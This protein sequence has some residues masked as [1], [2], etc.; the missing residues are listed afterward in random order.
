MG[1]SSVFVIRADYLE[2]FDD[3]TWV[4]TGSQ[5]SD[6]PDNEDADWVTVVLPEEM[7]FTHSDE[8]ILRRAIV[9]EVALHNMGVACIS[10]PIPTSTAD[11]A[12]ILIRAETD[13]NKWIDYIRIGM[14]N[15]DREVIFGCR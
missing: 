13:G 2:G 15:L 3:E 10:I 6:D 9:S 12:T 8:D 7:E 14:A 4:N 1:Q 11:T 5:L